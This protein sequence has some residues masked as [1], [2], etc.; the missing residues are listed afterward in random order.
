MRDIVITEIRIRGCR[1]PSAGA[2]QTDPA[3]RRP[4]E[5]AITGVLSDLCD[6]AGAPSDAPAIVSDC[7]IDV[8][9]VHFRIADGETSVFAGLAIGLDL[10]RRRQTGT[11]LVISSVDPSAAVALRIENRKSAAGRGARIL[12]SVLG[13]GLGC[14]AFVAGRPHPDFIGATVANAAALKDAGVSAEYVDAVSLA[15][16]RSPEFAVAQYSALGAL[17]ARRAGNDPVPLTAVAD[18]AGLSTACIALVKGVSIV[19]GSLVAPDA[20]WYAPLPPG[21]EAIAQDCENPGRCVLITGCDNTGTW[22]SA[23][24]ARP[25][26]FT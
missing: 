14:D 23:I 10:L 18:R 21:I 22:A 3:A 19:G 1:H 16:N 11:A 20:A 8:P 25:G 2:F 12:A 15:Q 26:G 4:D 7:P 24:I 5:D 13:V 9:G 17:F 6:S